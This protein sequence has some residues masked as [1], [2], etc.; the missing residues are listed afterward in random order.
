MEIKVNDMFELSSGK[1]ITLDD[2][3]Y[4]SQRYIF[5]NKLD[6]DEEPTKTFMVFR[7]TDKGLVE[8]KNADVLKPVLSH[9]SETANKKL[10]LIAEL[11]A[12]RG[13]E[14]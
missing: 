7:C 14:N 3:V 5:V 1:Y 11:Y 12:D 9:F 2:V 13:E 10:A 8:E 4:D 6:E